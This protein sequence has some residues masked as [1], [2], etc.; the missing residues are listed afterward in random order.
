M[1]LSGVLNR[2]S[3]V[4]GLSPD[5]TIIWSSLC[6]DSMNEI[7]MALKEGVDSGAKEHKDRLEN[8]V[9]CLSLYKYAL[10]K[11]YETNL[12]T[13]ISTVQAK[14]I[15]IKNAYQIWLTSRTAVADILEDNEFVFE[16]ID[17]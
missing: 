13:E 17:A 7:G 14:Q 11:L 4:S 10:Y 5:D 15:Y 12:D 1:D 8:A 3:L 16:G 6:Q 9:A 2:F